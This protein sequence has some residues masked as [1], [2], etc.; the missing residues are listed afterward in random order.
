MPWAES[1]ANVTGAISYNDG[2]ANTLAVVKAG[3][4]LA[5]KIT[6][7]SIGKFKDWYLPSRLELLI[8]HH[9]LASTKAFKPGGE[10]AFDP[11]WYWSSTQHAAGSVSA[12]MQDFGYGLQNDTRKSNDYRA[13][14]VRRIKI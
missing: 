12:W 3:S 7:L 9:E 5:K 13:R 1:T 4:A 8:A 14:A 6:E 2:L 11:A 10:Q